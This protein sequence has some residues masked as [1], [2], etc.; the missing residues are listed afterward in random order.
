MASMAVSSNCPI[1]GSALLHGAVE[2]VSYL[3]FETVLPGGG[4]V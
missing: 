1:T 4:V 3:P 2:I